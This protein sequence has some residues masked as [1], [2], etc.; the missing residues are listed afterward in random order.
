MQSITERLITLD[1]DRDSGL[2]MHLEWR[3]WKIQT[4]SC[5]LPRKP[6]LFLQTHRKGLITAG[7]WVKKILVHLLQNHTACPCG[8]RYPKH[9][10]PCPPPRG[11]FSDGHRTVTH[12][13]GLFLIYDLWRTEENKHVKLQ[14]PWGGGLHTTLGTLNQSTLYWLTCHFPLTTFDPQI[15]E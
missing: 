13:L 3:K 15:P 1:E 11:A 12:K 14:H 5:L 2:L 4:S 10:D 8:W 9:L 7:R 6:R